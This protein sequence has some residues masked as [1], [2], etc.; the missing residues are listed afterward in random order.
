MATSLTQLPLPTLTQTVDQTAVVE[1]LQGSDKLESALEIFP[2]SIYHKGLSSHLVKLLYTVLGPAGVALVQQDYLQARLIYEEHGINNSDLDAFYGDPFSFGRILSEFPASDATGMLTADEWETLISQDASYRNRAIDFLHG[3]RLGNSPAGLELVARSGVGRG[4]Q[5]VEQYK[6]LFDQHSD[7]PLGLYN[8]GQTTSTEE[9]VILPNNE[10]SNTQVQTITLN[11]PDLGP[12]DLAA[13]ITGSGGSWASTGDY[14]YVVAAVMP[15]GETFPSNEITVDITSTADTATLS[16]NSVVG[17]LSYRLYRATAPGGESGSACFVAQVVGE[18]TYADIGLAA[19]LGGVTQPIFALYFNGWYAPY[20]TYTNP[21]SGPQG[22]YPPSTPPVAPGPGASRWFTLNPAAVVAATATVNINTASP[23]TATFGGVTVTSG[24]YVRLAFQTSSDQD[25]IWIFNGP[26][27][28]MTVAPAIYADCF[29]VADYM[30]ALPSV[31]DGNLSVTGGASVVGGVTVI[32]PW[33]FTFT[34]TLANDSTINQISVISP[35]FTDEA[36]EI[37]TG[38]GLV[39]GDQ[40]IVAIAPADLYSLQIALDRIRSVTTIPTVHPFTSIR[41]N[42]P[43]GNIYATTQQNQVLRYVSGLSSVNWPPVDQYHWIVA[44]VEEQAPRLANDPQHDYQGFHNPVTTTASTT[45]V[46]Q[47]NQMESALFPFLGQQTD[48]TE[49]WAASQALA[50]NASGSVDLYIQQVAL[51]DSGSPV[52]MID[53]IYPFDYVTAVGGVQ[54]VNPP[55]NFWSSMAA[56]EGAET[57]LI[58]FGSPQAINY[59]DFEIARKP[60][61]ITIQ[62]DTMDQAGYFDWQ[63]VTPNPLLTYDDFISYT[64]DQQSLWYTSEFNFADGIN[65][66]IYTRYV[67]ITFTRGLAPPQFGGLPWTCNV[68]NLRLGRIVG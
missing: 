13:V 29:T 49:V 46:G 45:L 9:L 51:P 68:Q 31:G 64:T 24:Q 4:V 37:T 54:A 61:G 35:Y 33:V 53:G 36:F 39:N 23:G 5:V 22:A 18:T 48:P 8:Y 60:F 12:T 2:D 15:G 26:S 32:E 44:G 10:I 11:W 1:P 21:A 20:E 62:Y 3:V 58:D 55:S 25:G 7:D 41:Q 28:P 50:P 43:W 59:I 66:V 14:Y 42:Q 6:Y 34:N 63:A 16:W 57:L 27:S 52:A 19:G 56:T 67:L 30:N 38:T 40:E 47:F 17:A 65:D